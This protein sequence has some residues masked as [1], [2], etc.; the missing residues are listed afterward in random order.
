MNKK[1][2]RRLSFRIGEWERALR[3]EGSEWREFS[4]QRG[5]PGEKH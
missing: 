4:L 5:R 3:P 1:Y 2:Q